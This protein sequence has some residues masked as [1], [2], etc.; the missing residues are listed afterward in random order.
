MVTP[1]GGT[2]LPAVQTSANGTYAVSNVPG[3][4]GVL[5]VSNLPATCVQPTS[6]SYS[7]LTSGATVTVNIPV[8]CTAPVGTV[9]GI[10]TS[11]LGDR[12]TA[13]TVTIT[14]TSGAAL[15]S[16]VT[17]STG[18]YVV[19]SVPVGSGSGI[20][21]V[22]A[23]PANCANATS[24]AYSGLTSG[25]TLTV[26][27]VVTCT[28]PVG[29]VSGIVTS[30]LGGG[31]SGAAVAVTPV[32]GTALAA[33]TTSANGAYSVQG[34]PIG[35]GAGSVTV[36]NVPSGC[37]TASAGY[38]GLAPGGT[39]TANITVSCVVS[40]SNL[41]ACQV[42][43]APGSYTMA[44]DINGSLV[45]GACL[46]INANNVAL[47]C[48]G[49]VI[50]N[51]NGG[52]SMSI[53]AVHGVTINH[54]T[55]A[56]T[57]TTNTVAVDAS[58]SES[59]TISNST[60]MANAPGAVGLSAS[61]IRNFTVT[62][63]T[64]SV[65]TQLYYAIFISN[66]N[67]AAFTFNRITTDGG[68]SYISDNSSFG[69]FTNN[70]VSGA[71]GPAVVIFAN[72]GHN[73]V[74][75]N[76]ID[77]GWLGS[78]VP[79][80]AQGTDDGIVVSNEDADALQMNS[81]A[82]VWDISI[83]SVGSLTNSEIVNNTLDN[84]GLAGLGSAYGTSWSGN[85]VV[86]NH[87]SRTL[88][89][90]IFAYY[91]NSVTGYVPVTTIKFSNNLFDA[92]TFQDPGNLSAANT[93]SVIMTFE[94]IGESTT[95]LPLPAELSNNTIS[96]NTLPTSIAGFYLLPTTAFIDGGGNTCNPANPGN[97]LSCGG[98]TGRVVASLDPSAQKVSR[99][100]ALSGFPSRQQYRPSNGSRGVAVP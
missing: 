29:T 96:N 88:A 53:L 84:A 42:I 91:A 37:T 92:N 46:T 27:I 26:N 16:V 68:A 55:I 14:P 15:A 79:R 3:G 45:G 90:A 7:G 87:M 61:N 23:L 34:V 44:Q 62:Q 67:E 80:G 28:T 50:T 32:A 73:T 65:V 2:A 74:T 89:M 94:G 40:G 71:K 36:T 77:G 99:P 66:A 69:T 70:V 25:V 31:V 33:V 75:Q 98:P 49:H 83:E 76:H 6:K 43:S 17:D 21:A 60:L 59:V 38:S 93:A 12:I 97:A 24:K 8:T 41:T 51:S 52:A 81:I 1:T 5:V 57:G 35:S 54:C 78:L 13:A 22:S 85:K 48:A 95:G 86:G 20:V 18:K 19:S 100:W 9:S 10:V 11:S 39:A 4:A 64:V 82:N 47:D 30:S 63:S 56:A 58:G 72:G